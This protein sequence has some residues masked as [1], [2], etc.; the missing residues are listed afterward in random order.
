MTM[1]V[2]SMPSSA[3]EGLSVLDALP[4]PVEYG[5]IIARDAEQPDSTR[6]AWK[7]DA[8]SVARLLVTAARESAVPIQSLSQAIS[9]VTAQRSVL[10]SLRLRMPSLGAQAALRTLWHQSVLRAAIAERLV[11]FDTIAA[12]N[13]FMFSLLSVLPDLAVLSGLNPN[14]AVDELPPDI[15]R[16][17]R[18]V[19]SLNLADCADQKT[20]VAA[21]VMARELAEHECSGGG[22]LPA[23]LT[24]IPG[25]CFAVN[26]VEILRA[27]RQDVQTLIGPPS[28]GLDVLN[29]IN[30]LLYQ[31]AIVRRCDEAADGTA[32][33]RCK[34]ANQFSRSHVQRRTL[35][36]Q[37]FVHCLRQSVQT[38][39]ES[40][41]MSVVVCRPDDLEEI[42]GV[43]GDA[44]RKAVLDAALRLV[45]AATG[46]ADFV[47]SLPNDTFALLLQDCSVEDA[48]NLG[49]SIRHETDNLLVETDAAVLS[50][51][52]TCAV[53]G[54]QTDHVRDN[55][56]QV[57]EHAARLLHSLRSAGGNVVRS[58][59]L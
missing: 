34:L 46:S 44:M 26:G 24:S 29:R 12:E 59:E 5:D 20:D 6:H 21:A 22:D 23:H 35:R 3:T 39:R 13:G 32:V 38:A 43:Y 1:T 10:H 11:P 36:E 41:T 4:T 37:D 56:E 54:F 49:E 51:T 17:L 19:E 42:S 52:M 31:H 45:R 9:V 14:D 8:A 18:L 16:T 57:L 7:Y 40:R 25:S 55:P 33:P 53:V 2:N 30:A 50:T 47:G 28:T 15:A 58:V 48:S 27:A